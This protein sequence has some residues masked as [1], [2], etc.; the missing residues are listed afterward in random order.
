MK[1]TLCTQ[2]F[3][4]PFIGGVDVYTDRLACALKRL[5]HDVSIIAF[6][7]SV[8]TNG[9]KIT[10]APDSYDGMTVWRIKFAFNERPKQ[11]FDHL[12]DPEMGSIV[13]NILQ[14]TWPDLFIIVNFY[15]ITLA[16][17][18]AA[19][20]LGIPVGHIITDFLPICRRGTFMRW[21][22]KSCETG[23]SIKSC[24]TCFVSEDKL[25]R[26]AALLLDKLPEKTLVQ[27]ASNSDS[28]GPLHPLQPLMPYWRHVEIMR[29]RLEIVG[30][31][32]QKIDFVLAANHY[33][34]QAYISNGFS[35]DQVHF[36]PFGIDQD[37]PLTKVKQATSSHTRFLF[38]G[39]FQPYKGA[40]LLVETFNNLQSPKD[41]TLTIYGAP[42]DGYQEH[43]EQ[44][45]TMMATNERIHFGGRIAPSDLGQAF[46][47]AD[48]FVLPSTWHENSPLI[49]LD[50]LQAKTPVIASNIGGVTDIV[51]HGVN[52]LLFPMGNKQA[53]KQTLQQAIDEP[54][55]VKKLSAGI[56]LPT[57]DDY[58]KTMLEIFYSRYSVPEM[59][60]QI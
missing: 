15:V 45:K 10:A 44:L 60:R 18:E 4:P 38:V 53:L 57:I 48:Y 40:D 31:L 25:G 46:A 47:Q 56:N 14:D 7:S 1:I 55:L 33:I 11:A 21:D 17:V 37:R 12:Y 43:F 3:I 39:R 29:Q 30:P 36:L 49:V 42:D 35:A 51:K 26:K 6:D 32:R 20:E 58:A 16:T 8:D 52:G 27:W 34:M 2:K 41:A 22:N 54:D 9:K 19:K 13:K 59:I 24:A 50:A 23:E 5:G 28:W